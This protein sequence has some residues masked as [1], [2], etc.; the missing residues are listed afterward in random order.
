VTLKSTNRVSASCRNL[1][2]GVKERNGHVPLGKRKITD[3]EDGL[4]TMSLVFLPLIAR[5]LGM[6][7]VSLTDQKGGDTKGKPKSRGKNLKK[8]DLQTQQY[9][10]SAR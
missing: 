10:R 7:H 8:E 3:Q 6:T 4:N 5:P 9:L 1:G 2:G